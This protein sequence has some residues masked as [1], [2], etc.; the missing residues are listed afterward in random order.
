MARMEEKVRA[1]LFSPLDELSSRFSA[2]KRPLVIVWAPERV[3]TLWRTE[4]SLALA[5][6]GTRF[7]G[8]PVVSQ[9]PEMTE[10]SGLLLNV[11]SI[12]NALPG[13]GKFR[14]GDRPWRPI[15]L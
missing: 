15:G 4:M 5:E 6:N 14:R 11:L 12:R 13:P 10:L 3:C 7:L 1:L 9:V 2:R 8:R